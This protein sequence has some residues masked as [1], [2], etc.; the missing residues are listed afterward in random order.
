MVEHSRPSS[1][2]T[3]AKV[4]SEVYK[5][6]EFKGS[7]VRSQMGKYKKVGE[8]KLPVKKDL[9][10]EYTAPAGVIPPRVPCV[11]DEERMQQIKIGRNGQGDFMLLKEEGKLFKNLVKEFET[12][13]AYTPEEMGIYFPSVEE[14]YVIPLVEH[15][16]WVERAIPIAKSILPQVIEMLK[17]KMKV[18]LLEKC[19]GS[20]SNRWFVIKKKNGSLRLLIDAQRLNSFTIKNS[21][22]PPPLDEFA[23]SFAGY[24]ILSQFDVFGGYD[25]F[26]AHLKS[27]DATAIRTPLGLLR[28]TRLIQGGTNS[29]AIFQ[30]AMDT[31]YAEFV[32]VNL[33]AFIDDV[34]VKPSTK[35]KDETL[36]EVEVKRQYNLE[37]YLEDE[38]P[39]LI[40][41]SEFES[42]KVRVFVKE[43]YELLRKVFERTI[44]LGLTFGGP[45]TAIGC[46]D[47]DI[48]GNTVGEYGRKP[49]KGKVEKIL[50]WC[51]CNS[52]K[53]VRGFLGVVGFYRYW[54]KGF[55]II[56]E[57]LFRLTKKNEPFVWGLEQECSME[58]LKEAVSQYPVLRPP[59]YERTH[60]CPLIVGG[61]AGPPGTSGSLSQEDELGRRY[62]IRFT[63]HLWNK[64]QKNYAQIKKELASIT[65]NLKDFAIYL[66]GERFI[67]ETDCLPLIGMINNPDCIDPIIT[68][69]IMFI[70]VFDPIFVHVPG[71]KN[72]VADNLSRLNVENMDKFDVEGLENLVDTV[73]QVK[74]Q[75][76]GFLEQ[77][78]VE[79]LPNQDIFR[80]EQYDGEYLEIGRYLYSVG[81]SERY[82]KEEYKGLR[83]KAMNYFL[84]GGHLFV[85]PKGKYQVPRRVVCKE[86]EVK[87]ILIQ[88]HEEVGA[89]RSF[90][91]T[92]G[93]ITSRY[94]WLKMHEDILEFCKSCPEC[95]FHS[96]LK[97]DE[98]LKP[99]YSLGIFA[100]WGIDCI[101]FGKNAG[102]RRYAILAREDVSGWVEGKIIKS[103][104]GK[105]W[106][107]FIYRQI[108]CR[109]GISGL[110][111]ADNQLNTAAAISF[112]NK[113]RFHIAFTSAHHPQSNSVV[114]RGH[115]PIKDAIVKLCG[116][117]TK[118][119]VQYFYPALWA[120]RITVRRSTG[121]SPY[122][123]VFGQN[124]VLPIEMDVESWSSLNWRHGMTTQ[125]LLEN[126]IL[127]LSKHQVDIDQAIMNVME[128]RLLNKKYF[129]KVMR[130]RPLSEVIEIGDSV[131]LYDSNLEKK[132]GVKFQN[133]W[134]GPYLVMDKNQE[135][136]TYHLMEFDG[137]PLHKAVA[138]ERVKK[139]HERPQ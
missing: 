5:N 72:I 101:D 44:E 129:D 51:I 128:S 82:K 20:Y 50:E 66:I 86:E 29:V 71:K 98:P 96:S 117:D 43:H 125:E 138:G 79:S 89:H 104:K 54:I 15:E 70:K 2:R 67:Y 58:A 19:Y 135:N 126:R 94:Y 116:N 27:R 55:S 34:G 134:L 62:V 91:G 115:K 41:I 16:P 97:Y 90:A 110:M 45:K 106:I 37:E 65:I 10:E 36:V 127:Q 107:R 95:Q 1:Q 23:E 57:P 14:P 92:L 80:E 130:R 133:R 123:L 49:M 24:P 114:E 32:P 56:A 42:L 7:Y 102:K 25:E 4:I 21:G 78:P 139:F 87:S 74:V 109:Y 84:F 26:L 3:T 39:N 137:T 9:G 76:S 60:L 75:K 35:E 8:R 83:K 69:W 77:A 136:D 18:G 40:G 118:K 73:L 88:V 59:D 113:Y 48:V 6:G 11:I 22:M 124:C 30:N 31:G 81:N 47:I 93:I 100:K 131:L 99:T 112:M 17:S 46:T 103:L 63:S 53:E 111:V 108:I 122:Y 85:R 120:D 105:E 64:F 68:R 132:I 61:D 52:L 121:Y 13:F 119:W 28:Y 33:K 12:A 38:V